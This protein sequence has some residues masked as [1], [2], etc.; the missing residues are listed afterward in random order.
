MTS[1]AQVDFPALR[2][3]VAWRVLPLVF[4]I[5]IAAYLDR[6]NVQSATQEARKT[7]LVRAAGIHGATRIHGRRIGQPG[8]R[9]FNRSSFQP[10][11]WRGLVGGIA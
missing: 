2:R 3:K 10:R 9:G 4:L 6:A 5:Y 11:P 8:G 7:A 1:G